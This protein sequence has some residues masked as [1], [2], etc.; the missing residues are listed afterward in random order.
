MY[1]EIHKILTFIALFGSLY[2][3]EPFFMAIKFITKTLLVGL[4]TLSNAALM[5][6][7]A[8][9]FINTTVKKPKPLTKEL[10]AGIRLNTDGWGLFVDKGK[11]ISQ[12]A[13]RM[14]MFHDVRLFQF[15]FSE[16]RHPKELRQYGWDV[17]R[18][19]EKQY[20]FGKINNFYSLKFNFG[21]RKMIAGKPFPHSV[22]IHW[23]YAGG[24]T[25]GLL[26]PYY[27]EAYT[28]K[29]GGK[30]YSKENIKYSS[31]TAGTFLSPVYIV[32]SSGF[33][34]GIGETKIIP[35]LHLKSALHFD[36]AIDKFKVAAV[37]VGATAEYYIQNIE[38]MANQKA[39]PYFFNLYASIQ[40]GKRYN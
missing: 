14:D 22:S 6:Q 18:Q 23:L 36:Y 2:S 3:L 11:V 5:A 37:E 34:T 21:S 4:F 13:K 12:D 1:C 19:S 10:S 24:L 33:S 16:R 39:V 9:P 8:K 30:T 26:K 31:T 35:G 40:L 15:E 38:L 25:L 20:A 17:N 28:S 7:T 32:G 27:I 29:D